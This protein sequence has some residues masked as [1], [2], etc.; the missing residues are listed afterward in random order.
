MSD[1]SASNAGSSASI[2]ETALAL[3]VITALG[4]GVGVLFASLPSSTQEAPKPSGS[5]AT[6]RVK[7]LELP[8]IVTNLSAPPDTWVRFESAIVADSRFDSDVEALSGEI[9]NDII[10]YLRTVSLAQIE[11]ASGFQILRQALNERVAIRSRGK[12][13]ELAIRTLVVQ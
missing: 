10:A 12:V 11:G 4:A 9:N 5:S 13:G 6:A 8:P 2:K 3:L 7:V 1:T